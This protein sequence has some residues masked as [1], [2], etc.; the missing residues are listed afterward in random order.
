NLILAESLVQPI[1]LEIEDVHWID[2]N[3][4]EL[5][6]ELV[7]Q[8]GQYPI[9]LLMT[10]RY[11]DDGE[12]PRL[13]D[14]I[15]L[16][17]LGLPLLEIDLNVLP[18]PAVRDFAEKSLDGPIS[19]EFLQLLLRT[20]NS[21]PFYL[22]QV[23]EYF[24]ESGLL[25][26]DEAGHW[27]I[28]DENVK[29][30]NS[31]NAILTARID[32]LSKQV[33]DTVKAAAV[34]GREFEVPV[35]SE[36][37]KSQEGFLQRNA[38]GVL[39]VRDEID[40][41]ERVQIWRAMNELR[42]I[43]RH[44]LLREAVYSMQLRAR[45]QQLHRLIAE[46]I[47]RLYAKQIEER[48]AD[49]AFHYEQA[50]VFS[51]TCE[52]LRKA[53]DYA[54]ENYQNQQAL[55]FYEKLL[56][57][58]GNQAAREERVQAHLRRGKLL[59]VLGNWEES[60]A[61]L[62]QALKLAKPTHD[63]LLIGQANNQMGHLL[64]LKGDYEAA[65]AFLERAIGLFESVDEKERGLALAYG[66]LGN[67]YFRQGD[68]D[69]AQEYFERSMATGFLAQAAA[70]GAQIVAN[71][72]LTHMNRG[73]FDAGIQAIERQLPHH[74]GNQD[75]QGMATLLVNLG[76]VQYEKG[77]YAAARASYEEGLALA[78][79][80]G[81]KQLVSIAIGCLGSVFQQQGDY[82]RAMELF[83]EDLTITEEL[84]DKQ[85]IAI[86]LGLIGEL[87][88]IRGDF[89]RAI[90][91]LQKNLMLCEEL[92]YQKGIAKAVNTLG[93]VF[94][95]TEQYDRSLHFYDRAIE[96]TRKID[97]RLVL[98][99]SLIEKGLVLIKLDRMAELVPLEEE[100]LAIARK[101]GNP[102][103]LF[104]ARLMR[105]RTL[106]LQDKR[107]EALQLLAELRQA[108]R[109]PGQLAEIDYLTFRINPTDEAIR[110]RAI[111]QF[112]YLYE[113]TPKYLY[114]RR[115]DVLRNPG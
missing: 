37:M 5:L 36:V 50:G 74:R 40:M 54:R 42:Y 65:K 43:F 21:N 1:V 110:Q 106:I 70:E 23:L 38:K 80:L 82:D 94:Y 53:A 85:G 48:Y 101:L 71:L 114:Q 61:A 7:R 30:S 111:Q 39:L 109:T 107:D 115:L 45:L 35:L 72:A 22:E 92:G 99:G 60:E 32:R 26:R 4:T 62:Q 10:S 69:Q 95:F 78:E 64:L 76:I 73:R 88:S 31:I 108:E 90:E 68:Y 11:K 6:R 102:D 24:N 89:H 96:V 55:T 25:M 18:T 15:T 63:V 57:Q 17:E 34:I 81:N 105:I 41:A 56:D 67:L 19:E 28:Q 91:H 52:Y 44:S 59:E 13:I 3:S 84:G 103:L 27:T 66:N 14:P 93:D 47:E 98:A 100:A 46:A 51:K 8:M 104:E 112:E 2:E 9:F 97:N 75:K 29:L 83:E 12:K 33:R 79:E 86:A 87:L 77:D 20:T 49:L 16:D 58:L 113:R